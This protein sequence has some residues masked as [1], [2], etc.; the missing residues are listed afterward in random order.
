[1]PE[2]QL[3]FFPKENNV[4]QSELQEQKIQRTFI[5]IQTIL[6]REGLDITVEHIIKLIPIKEDKNGS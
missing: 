3:E 2:E 6:I 1:M 4:S 5:D